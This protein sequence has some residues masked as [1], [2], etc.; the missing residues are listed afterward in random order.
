MTKH[1]KIAYFYL[2]ALLPLCV[3]ALTWSIAT[4]PLDRAS[5]EILGLGAILVAA[6]TQLRIQLPKSNR[7]V[8]LS[9][10]LVFLSLLY[11]GG[12]YAVLMCAVANFV[13]CVQRIKDSTFIRELTNF[14]IALI[15]V[16]VTS[17]GIL[18]L[19]GP[20]E[21]VLVKLSSLTFA[22]VV[23]SLAI[24]T[25]V[26]NTILNTAQLAIIGETHYWEELRI[27]WTDALLVRLG[28]AL[29]AGLG[30]MAIKDTNLFLVFT[31]LGFFGILQIA[32]SRYQRDQKQL[33]LE[34]A[35][36]EL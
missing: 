23:S 28:S 20:P 35:K 7:D 4:F 6:S 15:T 10:A 21:T 12:E 2:A 18:T 9:H 19:F 26:L 5:Y 36:A 27:S 3:G 32:F 30:V 16:F 11:F 22:L 14:C 33:Q 25:F 17:V 34:A 31:V 1:N 29:M 8:P 24:S 13:T